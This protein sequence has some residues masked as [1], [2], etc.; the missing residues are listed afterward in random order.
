ML[1][2]SDA[3]D[4]FGHITQALPI[5][6]RVGDNPHEVV[7][8][9]DTG[10]LK[11]DSLICEPC[12]NA[13]TSQRDRSWQ[14]LSEFLRHS[15]TPILPGMCI[16][17]GNVFPN[18]RRESML[19]VHLYFLKLFGCLVLQQKAPIN[20]QPFARS[21][22]RGV[23]HPNVYL[24]FIALPH[25]KFHSQAALTFIYTASVHDRVVL[26][27]WSYFVGRVAVNVTYVESVRTRS[28]NV[29]LWHPSSS[30]KSLIIGEK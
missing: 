12:N 10:K 30:A 18:A 13:R 21:L 20:I 26:A 29:H 5:Y 8:G 9:I 25:P 6:L 16:R 22:L 28:K 2:A 3:R 24:S 11:F 1:K 4:L 15:D 14:V 17:F 19:G 27:T 7:R 23:A